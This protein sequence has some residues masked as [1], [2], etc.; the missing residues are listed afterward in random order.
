MPSATLDAT[1]PGL[2]GQSWD[3][4]TQGRAWVR[5]EVAIRRHSD[6]RVERPACAGFEESCTA[7][8]ARH[9]GHLS[10]SR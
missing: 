1:P 6:S 5:P 3:H 2:K 9:S 4:A 7:A 10:G 8:G